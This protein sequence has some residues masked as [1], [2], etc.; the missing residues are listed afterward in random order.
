MDRRKATDNK[1]QNYK[2]LKMGKN[3]DHLKE[4]DAS[5]VD[6][7]KLT[8]LSPEVVRYSC[9]VLVFVVGII[10]RRTVQLSLLR[11]INVHEW[12]GSD[13]QVDHSGLCIPNEVAISTWDKN[14][15]LPFIRSKLSSF[16]ILPR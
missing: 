11:W 6:P 16:D 4:Q 9:S 8:A 1:Q 7:S 2:Y 5:T 3:C 10:W 12:I 15:I 13:L 14:V